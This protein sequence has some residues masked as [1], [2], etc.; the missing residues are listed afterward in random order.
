MIQPTV[1]RIVLFNPGTRAPNIACEPGE[2][3]AAIITKVWSDRMVNLAVFDANGLP[4]AWTSIPLWQPGDPQ[5]DPANPSCEWMPYQLKKPTGS[6]SGE[7]AAGQ[8]TI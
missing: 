2:K 5:I 1:G 4:S 7:K 6:E 8:Q 3:C